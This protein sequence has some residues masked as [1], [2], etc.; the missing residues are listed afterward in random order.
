MLVGYSGRAALRREPYGIFAQSNNCG[1]RET[2][3]VENG[4]ATTFVPR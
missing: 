1:A 4:S 2:A 3:V